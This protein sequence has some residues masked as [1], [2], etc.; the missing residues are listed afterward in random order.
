MML[1]NKAKIQSSQ[2]HWLS[3]LSSWKFGDFPKQT[4]VYAT[5]H[6]RT[7][8]AQSSV[9]CYHVVILRMINKRWNAL[10]DPWE[11]RDTRIV[12]IS[13]WDTQVNEKKY[14]PQ[15]LNCLRRNN[16]RLQHDSVVARTSPSVQS[17]PGNSFDI[18]WAEPCIIIQQIQFRPSGKGL[19]TRM[20][21]DYIGSSSDCGCCESAGKWRPLLFS[22]KIPYFSC[23]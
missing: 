4:S 10:C 22:C 12:L 2:H 9:H 23:F 8:E 6:F 3:S 13:S 17:G 7:T 11:L 19:E 18:N 21:L 16:D 20:K 5:S 1:S 14:T 15:I